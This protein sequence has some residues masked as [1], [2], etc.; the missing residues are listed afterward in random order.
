MTNHQSS[1]AC[2]RLFWMELGKA[3]R[4]VFTG[5]RGQ[6]RRSAELPEVAK[7]NG[8]LGAIA[9]SPNQTGRRSSKKRRL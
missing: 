6:Q 3:M 5:T 9:N 2:L 4:S 7:I 1:Y 8:A